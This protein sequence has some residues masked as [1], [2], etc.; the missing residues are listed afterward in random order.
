MRGWWRYHH[1]FA[2]LLRAA[3]TKT[4]RRLAQLH[5]NAAAW[6]QENGLAD[7]AIGHAAAAGEML[8]AAGSSS[9]T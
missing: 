9:S 3:W 7:D 4:A 6:R 8:W 5:R 1:L 2:D